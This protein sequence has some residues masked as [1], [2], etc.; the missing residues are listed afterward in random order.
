[1]NKIRWMLA[2]TL[3][4]LLPL[5]AIEVTADKAV[6]LAMSNN[7]SLQSS[8]I[9][10]QSA[11]R[12]E[13]NSW[14]GML[15]TVQ[16]TA[17]ISHANEASSVTKKIASLYPAM[18]IN[19]DPTTSF[20]FGLSVSFAFNPALVTNM[21]T[22]KRQLAAGQI[23]YAEAKAQMERNVKKLFYAILLQ[24]ESMAIQESALENA[25]ARMDQAED[26]YT[27]GYATE[28]SALQAQVSYQNTNASTLKAR[29]AL[30]QQMDN[31]AFLL[32]LD[33]GDDLVLVGSIDTELSVPEEK[34]GLDAVPRRFD[35]S[36]LDSQLSIL[37]SQRKALDQQI[38]VPS[39]SVSLSWQPYLGDVTSDWGDGDNWYDAGSAPSISLAWDLS[40]MLPWS[41]A[42]QNVASLEENRKKLV[43]NRELAV[44]N[45]RMEI[46][47]LYDTLN[48]SKQAIAA[49]EDSIQLAQRSY[50]MTLAAYQAG[51]TELLDV[52][53]S[54]AQLNQAKLAR[55]NEQY[56]Y[57]SALLD[58]QYATRTNL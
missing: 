11:Q 17:T 51:T 35:I 56:N 3:A 15:P 23:T 39:L 4:M 18:G 19:T 46:K 12:A 53:D 57:L 43:L 38:W 30:S 55:L 45:A 48:A 5:G 32:G 52:R 34:T 8:A 26:L 37:D 54:E 44:D 42:R 10:L 33:D 9:D 7:K 14:N 29:Q 40:A 21:E 36:A 27:K 6:A 25:K 16:T 41:K 58:L 50:D 20:T 24:Q 22:A 47:K 31:F 2:I 28:L 49:S 13:K 1:M